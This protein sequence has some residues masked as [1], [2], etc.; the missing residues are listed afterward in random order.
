MRPGWPRF[1]VWLV[2]VA[3]VVLAASVVL[4][5]AGMNLALGAGR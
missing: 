2:I 4:S 5:L 1:V 3:L